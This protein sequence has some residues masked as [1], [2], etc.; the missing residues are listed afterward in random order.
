MWSKKV[1]MEE[2]LIF[3]EVGRSKIQDWGP[4][5]DFWGLFQDQND[6]QKYSK[7]SRPYSGSISI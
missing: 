5:S 1:V 7:G 3:K 4:K 2:N 6:L